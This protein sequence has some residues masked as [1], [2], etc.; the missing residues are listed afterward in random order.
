MKLLRIYKSRFDDHTLYVFPLIN[1][2][3]LPNRSRYYAIHFHDDHKKALYTIVKHT[4]D[5]NILCKW[6][7]DNHETLCVSIKGTNE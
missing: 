7:W 2:T 6:I 4:S 1:I 5:S 3:D